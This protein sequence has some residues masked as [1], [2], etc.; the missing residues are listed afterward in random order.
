MKSKSI[1]TVVLLVFVGVSV[2]CLVI[3]ETT[4]TPVI[5]GELGQTAI[6]N[7]ETPISDDVKA[8]SAEPGEAKGHKLI[9]YYFHRTQR[10]YTCLTIERYAEEA[11]KAAFP[12]SL[13]SGELEWRTVNL[14]EPANEHF[15][16]DFQLAASSLVLVDTQDG[17]Q[18]EWRNLE[19]VWELVGDE[20]EFKAYVEAQ[21]MPFLDEDL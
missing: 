8:Q 3:Q 15:V 9:A 21:A 13:N 5:E 10:C 7:L 12:K 1:V 18:K 16:E 20:L 2:A 11:L 4:P 6:T 17:K 14:E 19:R